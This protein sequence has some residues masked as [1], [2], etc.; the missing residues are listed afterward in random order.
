M[1]IANEI[2]KK[3]K[4]AILT[5]PLHVNY[6]GILQAYAMQTV[7]QRMG[8]EVEVINHSSGIPTCLDIFKNV[9]VRLL[10]RIRRTKDVER[11]DLLKR[12]YLSGEI[13][14][15]VNKNIIF[16][17]EKYA[18]DTLV[19]LNETNFNAFLVGSDQVW[20]ALYTPEIDLYFLSFLKKD[21]IKRIAYS[22]SFGVN[23]REYT[24]EQIKICR[25]YFSLFDAVSVREYSGL[26]LI[27]D[28]HWKCKKE[29]VHTLDPTMLLDMN[30]YVQLFH[31]NI[32]V[33]TGRLFA[34]ILDT[35]EDANDIR[36]LIAAA[37]GLKVEAID[38]LEERMKPLMSPVQWI[39]RIA[40]SQFVVTDSF[41]GCVYSILFHRPFIVVRNARRGNARISSL[42]RLLQLEERIVSSL[43]D[44]E[45]RKEILLGDI[46]YQEVD[47]LLNEQ[48]KVSYKFLNE[49]LS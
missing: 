30:D 8:H 12:R 36:K 22:V 17:K 1:E 34:Y 29:C 6:G 15:F 25:K 23:D 24:P 40:T 47:A 5:L 26:K 4:I 41:H 44:F 38:T 31:F 21:E 16:T 27:D 2:T 42:L 10:D 18:T 37:K 33:T 9:C 19:K 11:L 3:M 13:I 39:E 46:N 7:L 14:Q 20:R 49:S 43:T 32:K 35:N 48:R 45:N 28:Y